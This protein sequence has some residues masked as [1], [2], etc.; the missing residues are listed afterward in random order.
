MGI[1]LSTSLPKLVSFLPREFT[2]SRSG[3]QPIVE[4]P[5]KHC[6]LI[7]YLIN[8]KEGEETLFLCVGN[9]GQ[10]SVQKPYV[11]Y[12]YFKSGLELSSGF[13]I[14]PNDLT[15]Q[16][17]LPETEDIHEVAKI[18]PV[19]VFRQYI[20]KLLPTILREKGFFTLQS[21]LFRFCER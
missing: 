13:F 17:F 7:H 3:Q 11:I 14:S 16:E 19:S 9:G 12:H 2:V 8:L 5:D 21:L 6:I 18:E 15:A 1:Q 10:Y 4:L 20:H